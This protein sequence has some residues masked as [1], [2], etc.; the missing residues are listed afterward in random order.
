MRLVMIAAF[1]V[2]VPA[3]LALATRQPTAAPVF[4]LIDYGPNHLDN[5]EYVEWVRKQ[6]PELLHFGKDVPMTHVFGPIAAVGGENQAHGRNRADIRRLT[7]GEV[8][9]RI[10]A[11][12]RM[13]KALHDAGAKMV[14]PY[15]SAITYG[16][17]PKT[18]E[19][20]FNFFDHW[21]EYAEFEIGPRP[22]ND[23]VDWAAHKADGS[24]CT[25]GKELAPPYYAGMNRYVACIEH[26]D[27][28]RWLEEVTRLV[29]VAG[30]DGAFPDNSS[31]VRCYASCCQVAF[32]KYLSE[33]FTPGQLQELFGT[34]D[35]SGVKLPAE[36]GS[37]LWVEAN[38][39]WQTSLARH[40]DAMRAAG[41]RVNPKFLLFPN[42]GTPEHSAEYLAGHVDYIMFEGG[43]TAPEGAGCVVTPIIGQVARRHVIDN[44]LDYRYC[45][46]VP[47]DIR[48]MLL[49]LGK[50]PAAQKLCLAEAAAFG[51]GAYNGVTVGTREILRPY[52]EFFFKHKSLFE[53]K[54]SSARVALLYFPMRD[55]YPDAGH[56][57]GAVRVKDRLGSMQIP[58]DCFSE[59]FCLTAQA[60]ALRTYDVCIAPE[61]KY[62]SDEHLNILR[63]YV[64]GG[65]RL[66]LIGEFATHDELC[67]KRATPDWL[68]P[69][70]GER[71]IENG[72][73]VHRSGT[74]TRT[75]MLGLL[76]PA[77]ELRVVVARGKLGEPMLRVMMYRSA[78]DHIV[79]LLNYNCPVEG[80]TPVLPEKNV[81]VRVPMPE[82]KSPAAVISY[83]P[84]GG[85]SSLK[86]ETRDG[87]C[88]F[89]VPEV[90]IYVLCR[91]KME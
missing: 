59:V 84:E 67:R 35:P 52:I 14:M 43:G 47:G 70:D 56:R 51:S 62:L 34:R 89:T 63:G 74:P 64:R 15:I 25:F 87:A 26:P 12:R 38:R 16:G 48:P 65:G 20:F 88:W 6:P 44:I 24:F 69:P 36:K 71:K 49:K 10:A 61:L 66:L 2:L 1:A 3:S 7:P 53:D 5:P 78:G 42:L 39:F 23:P 18:R 68:P 50:T 13:N 40:L 81:Q 31:P 22:K 90:D 60:E 45:A 85:E 4:Y 57:A 83:N 73:V 82:G 41:R 33:K 8:R 21:D 46:D 72:A 28:R 58:F 37:L 19:G 30:Y 91:M 80:G 75:E 55:Y 54:I 29:A 86:F 76:A 77:G 17:D 79:H 9:E 32:G 11:L 27:W